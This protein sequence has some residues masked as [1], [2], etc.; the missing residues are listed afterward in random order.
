MYFIR[1]NGETG[2]NNPNNQDCF[3]PGE[4]PTYPRTAFNYFQLCLDQEFVRIGWPDV[5]DLRGENGHEALTHCYRLPD[6]AP[7][8]QRYLLRFAGIPKGSTILMPN[9]AQPGDLA[10]GTT[11]SKYYFL[12]NV[13]NDPY[14]CA[15]RI[16][17]DW[18]RAVYHADQFDISI[19]GGLWRR[20]FYHIRDDHVIR[21]VR[22]A[23]SQ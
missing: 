22:S 12:H 2:H 3:V 5:G 23:R 6:L 8:K 11:S 16:N 17:V 1:V 20:A 21:K 14:E 15:H 18:D 10:I 9:I 4:P 7:Y 13:P 19:R